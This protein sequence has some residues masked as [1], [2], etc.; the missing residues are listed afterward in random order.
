MTVTDPFTLAQRDRQRS[1][2]QIVD[3]LLPR[4][5]GIA[6]DGCHKI[7]VLLDDE[8]VRIQSSCGYGDD[9]HGSR[10]LTCDKASADEMGTTL[11]DWFDA[12]CGLRFINAIE[13]VSGD[14]NGG[15]TDL[16][17]QFDSAFIPEDTDDNDDTEEDPS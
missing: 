8:Q 9:D 14:P 3:L 10:L 12:S 17:A 1:L 7:Y 11:R 6:W 4:A 2:W 16:I 13:T 15:F 5:H